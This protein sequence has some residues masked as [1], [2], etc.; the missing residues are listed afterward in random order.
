MT[1]NSAQI[2]ND[3][4]WH[5]ANNDQSKS[6]MV[7]SYP[8]LCEYEVC[9]ALFCPAQSAIDGYSDTHNHPSPPAA[10]AGLVRT[11][12]NE[13]VWMYITLSASPLFSVMSTSKPR[14][15]WTWRWRVWRRVFFFSIFINYIVTFFKKKA[16]FIMVDFFLKKSAVY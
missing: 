2:A 7:A 15:T 8:R 1:V 11:T 10:F 13:M 5:R 3:A 14:L 6:I 9:G 4:D 16:C 12:P